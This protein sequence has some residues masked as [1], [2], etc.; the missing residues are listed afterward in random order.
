MSDFCVRFH[1]V[2]IELIEFEFELLHSYSEEI[3]QN[4]IATMELSTE[5]RAQIV[6]LVK[7]GM[8]QTDVATQ[9]NVSQPVVSITMRRFNE[10]GGF[11]S[12]KRSG[13]PKCTTMQTDRLIRRCVIL[14]PSE[15]S[16]QIVLQLPPSRRIS[17]STVRRRL[18]KQ[19]GLRA[20][21]PAKKPLLSKKN[22]QDR[23]M[24]CRKFESYTAEQWSKVLFSDETNVYLFHSTAPYVRR[25]P[26]ERYNKRY[27][28]RTVKHPGYCMV[29]ASFS[30]RGRG[31][32]YFLPQNTTMNG[33]TYLNM[34]KEKLEPMMDIHQCD[35]LQHDGAPCH[36]SKIGFNRKTFPFSDLGPVRVRISIPS[37]TSSV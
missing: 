24:F 11:A 31:N 19:F 36:R 3:R 2:L 21:R 17:S 30:A 26:S 27:C 34:L 35:L 37:R 25:P 1:C 22:I 32:L 18:S 29:W 14:N 6:A 9:L 15:T 23:L 12:K 13:R 10:T 8:T 5:K 4:F 28:V 20:Y 16:S 33:K 7:S